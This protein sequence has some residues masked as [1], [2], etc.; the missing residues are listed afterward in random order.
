[1]EDLRRSLRRLVVATVV[2]Y[3]F[4]GGVVLTNYL[5]GRTTNKALCALR[6]DLAQRAFTATEYL[7]KN[8]TAVSE[9][10]RRVIVGGIINQQRTI[11]ALKDLDCS[12]NAPED[13]LKAIGTPKP[14]N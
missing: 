11:V 14:A 1:M 5:N 8:P 2:L 7:N 6:A 9:V 12:D 4:L 10:Q 13:A 3:L